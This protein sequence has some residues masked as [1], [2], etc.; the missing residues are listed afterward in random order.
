MCGVVAGGA[1][2]GLIR[3]SDIG[4]PLAF[5]PNAVG[6]SR[7]GVVVAMVLIGALAEGV[8]RFRSGTGAAAAV[9]LIPT[10]A[11]L[12][13]AMALARYRFTTSVQLL[14]VLASDPFG[15]GVDLFGTRGLELRAQPF[16]VITL[17]WAQAVTAVLGSV[18]GIL[19]ARRRAAAASGRQRVD[20]T[21]A[22]VTLLSLLVGIGVA[23][24]GAF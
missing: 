16:D 13:L 2:F 12:A 8:T 9:G 7:L 5:G 11:G 15:A 23:A 17:I 1:L 10:A 4:T 18:G 21:L 24:I 14:P 19:L 6:Y 22:A 20:A 3:D